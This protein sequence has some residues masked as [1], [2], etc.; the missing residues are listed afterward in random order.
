MLQGPSVTLHEHLRAFL[1]E[2]GN[3]G[4][5]HKIHAW[6]KERKWARKG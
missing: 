2:D 6:I 1:G 3:A 5:L 4:N